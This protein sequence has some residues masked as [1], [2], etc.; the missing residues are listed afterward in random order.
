ML[1]L[2]SSKIIECLLLLSVSK[3]VRQT[4]TILRLFSINETA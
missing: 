3:P 4:N 1:E 2:E